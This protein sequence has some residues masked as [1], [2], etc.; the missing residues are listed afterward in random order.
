MLSFVKTSTL[1]LKKK[2]FIKSFLQHNLIK[3]IQESISDQ[4]LNP[5][6]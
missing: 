2:I 6:V 4:I 1:I 5:I 3:G